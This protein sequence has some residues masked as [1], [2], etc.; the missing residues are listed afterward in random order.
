MRAA[1]ALLVFLVVACNS[2]GVSSRSSPAPSPVAINSGCA[3][4]PV[5]KG[6]IPAWLDEAGGHNNP[7]FLNY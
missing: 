1:L 3:S 5:L 7:T 4:T 6:S 2:G